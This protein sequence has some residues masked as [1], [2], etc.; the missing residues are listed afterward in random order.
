MSNNGARS[1]KKFLEC[2]RNSN[3]GHGRPV[4]AK[5]Q[6]P[7]FGPENRSLYGRQSIRDLFSKI[8]KG[9]LGKKRPSEHRD[10]L[11]RTVSC[12]CP[13]GRG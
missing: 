11:P 6:D 2:A 10:L 4:R 1:Q 3:H 8:P 5:S 9:S 13:R 12:G 7:N